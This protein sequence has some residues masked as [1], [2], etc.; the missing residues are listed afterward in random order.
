MSWCDYMIP[1]RGEWN[2]M[3]IYSIDK[4][5][6]LHQRG[7][8]KDRGGIRGWMRRYVKRYVRGWVKRS[9]SGDVSG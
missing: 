1:E 3:D 5:S 4:Y 8:M 7:G 2:L 9:M 6:P